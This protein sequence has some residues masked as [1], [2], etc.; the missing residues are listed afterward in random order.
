M[1][2]NLTNAQGKTVAPGAYYA[3]IGYEDPLTKGIK[4]LKR[5]VMVVP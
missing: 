4:K 5:K 2:W 1:Q 3:V